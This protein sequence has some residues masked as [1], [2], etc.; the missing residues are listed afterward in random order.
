MTP[1]P[2]IVPAAQLHE[3][4]WLCSGDPH[5]WYYFVRRARGGRCIGRK[6]FLRTVDEP[7][8]PLVR[9]LHERGIATTPSCSGH[10]FSGSALERVYSSLRREARAIRNG[11]LRLRDV[12]SGAA[13]LFADEHYQLPWTEDR[14]M[15][16]ARERQRHGALGICLGAYARS[17]HRLLALHIPSVRVEEREGTVFFFTEAS[18]QRA[19]DRVWGD[20]TTAVC[21]A[22]A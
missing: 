12:E 13:Y 8:R 17:R 5:A 11:G 10:A 9:L 15:Q 14:F 18:G 4:N 1:S 19:I 16:D 21:E 20:V 2:A 6:E 3:C 7:L 22:L